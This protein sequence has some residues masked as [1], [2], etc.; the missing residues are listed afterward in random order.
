MSDDNVVA[1]HEDGQG[2]YWLGSR[3]DGAYYWHPR[4]K[5]IRSFSQ[6]GVNGLSNDKITSIEE[7]NRQELWLGSRNGLNLLNLETKEVQ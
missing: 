4:S 1:L 3:F 2:G 5:A 7:K 6:T